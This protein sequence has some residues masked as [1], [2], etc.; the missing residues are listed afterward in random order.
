VAPTPV[1]S[2]PIENPIGTARSSCDSAAESHI[3]GEFNG[4][5]GET[6]D[7]LDNGEIWQQATYHYHYHYAYHPEVIIFRT[8]SGTCHIRV[9]HDDDEGVD[10]ARIK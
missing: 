9:I 5:E 8:T 10:V 6:I 4:W 2:A 3:D 7:K 1:A